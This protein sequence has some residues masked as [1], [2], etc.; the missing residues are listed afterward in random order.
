MPSP[1]G[2]HAAGKKVPFDRGE[3][4]QQAVSVL[5][6]LYEVRLTKEYERRLRPLLKR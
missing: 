4:R 6:R 2:D 1:E 5:T 3:V